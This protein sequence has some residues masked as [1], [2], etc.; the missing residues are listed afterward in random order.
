MATGVRA[1]VI[2]CSDKTSRGERVDESGPALRDR[3]EAA[4]WTVDRIVVVPDQIEAIARAIVTAIDADGIRLVVTTG[5]T[6]LAPRDVTTE[7][8]IRVAEKIVPGFG[9]LMR[10]RSLE[11]T[12]MAPL[13]RTQAA[14]RRN[15]LILNLPGSP[16]GAVENFSF[17]SH[18]IPHALDLLSGDPIEHAP[19]R[20]ES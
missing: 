17:V 13:S 14:T 16:T 2:T 20:G 18:L 8:T 6:G 3:I 10:A 19:S 1:R 15:A 4:G 7:A 9:E 5:G 12:S 11:K